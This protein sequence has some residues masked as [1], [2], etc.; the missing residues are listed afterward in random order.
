MPFE[1]LLADLVGK[2]RNNGLLIDT[3][4]LLLLVV[5]IYDRR[6]ITSFK[7]T[8]AYTPGDF[9]KIGWLS[10]Q[11]S[12]LWAT[13]NILTEVDNLGR[14]LPSREHLGFSNALRQLS[15]R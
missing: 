10:K 15:F 9:Q 4:L 14:Q 5:G 7:R 12:Q 13:P 6:R 3:N 1:L 11:F 2:H 8:A